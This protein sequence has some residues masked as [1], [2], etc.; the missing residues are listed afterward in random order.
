MANGSSRVRA[1]GLRVKPPYAT[2]ARGPRQPPNPKPLEIVRNELGQVRT[3]DLKTGT[4]K[5]I[6]VQRLHS[7]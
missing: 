5:F 7:V 1:L 3:F 6:T 2:S 4:Y